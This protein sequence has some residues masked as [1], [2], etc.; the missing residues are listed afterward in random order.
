MLGIRYSL[1]LVLLVIVALYAPAQTE[2][3]QLDRTGTEQITSQEKSYAVPPDLTAEELKWYV[4]FQEG[5]LLVDGWQD[6]SAGILAKTP[7]AEKPA[8]RKLLRN[9]G[10]RIGL[11][12]SRDNDIRKVDT[13]MLKEWGKKLKSAARNNPEKLDVVLL[14]INTELDSLLN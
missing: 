8:Q 13:A 4:K 5:N 11:E 14:D 9:L 2:A 1:A 10:Y 3:E 6:I 7:D 12:W